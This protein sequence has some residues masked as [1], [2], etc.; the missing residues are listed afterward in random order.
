MSGIKHQLVAR[1]EEP[2]RVCLKLPVTDVVT[3]VVTLDH[4]ALQYVVHAPRPTATVPASRGANEGMHTRAAGNRQTHANN[5][6][7]HLSVLKLLA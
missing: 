1:F 7:M 6:T 3:P 2:F 5:S 4:D